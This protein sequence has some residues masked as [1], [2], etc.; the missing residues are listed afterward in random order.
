M[1]TSKTDDAT[2]AAPPRLDEDE[3]NAA[4]ADRSPQK[5]GLAHLTE[6]LDPVAHIRALEREVDAVQPD[7][8]APPSP[9][10][11]AQPEPPLSVALLPAP[12]PT[13]RALESR[14]SM[15][16]MRPA[17]PAAAPTLFRSLTR[18]GLRPRLCALIL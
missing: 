2:T 9:Q 15:E 11:L 12:S 3:L 17:A 4:A 6:E 16:L 10:A 5:D 8:V 1:A 18:L 13:R 14:L 7:A